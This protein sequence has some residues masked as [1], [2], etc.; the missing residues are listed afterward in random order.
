MIA[1]RDGAK[2]CS[3]CGITKTIAD[4]HKSGSHKDGLKCHCKECAIKDA[5]EYN[6][7]HSEHRR[8]Y[9]RN[10][11]KI[12][13]EKIK[14]RQIKRVYG[15]TKKEYLRKIAEQNNSC[16]ICKTTFEN[17][18]V[19]VDH[20]HE[21]GVVRDLLCLK[22]NNAL[23]CINDDPKIAMKLIKYLNKWKSC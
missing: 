16:S 7:K 18:K 19:N 2:R 12:N 17:T 1:N 20:D 8:K 15:I 3:K 11:N 14:Y 10:Y 4:F 6:K 5:A 21:T 22:C 13:R 23:G 9:M